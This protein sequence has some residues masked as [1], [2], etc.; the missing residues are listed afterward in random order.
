M[1]TK[2]ENNIPGPGSYENINGLQ[3]SVFKK[4]VAGYKGNVYSF[5]S[6][7]NIVLT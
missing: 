7:K 5:Y 4:V 2:H 6:Y 1:T 3:F